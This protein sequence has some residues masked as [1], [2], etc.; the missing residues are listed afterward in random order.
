MIQDYYWLVFFKK[1]LNSLV[2]LELFQCLRKHGLGP[3]GEL[4][5]LKWFLG[6]REGT[7]EIWADLTSRI[8]RICVNVGFFFP[9]VAVCETPH[10]H[11]CWHHTVVLSTLEND[12]WVVCSCLKYF[13]I[14]C[15]LITKSSFWTKHWS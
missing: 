3:Y 12:K 15:W 8:K 4:N 9:L 11:A 14:L 1:N 6:D 7:F 10:T 5:I 13:C 2:L